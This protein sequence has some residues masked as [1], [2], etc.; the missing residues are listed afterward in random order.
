MFGVGG[1]L[2]ERNSLLL[3]FGWD[4]AKLGV[5]SD[6][7]SS[8]FEEVRGHCF[9][10]FINLVDYFDVVLGN[11]E[12]IEFQELRVGFFDLL[13]GDFSNYQFWT[14][15]SVFFVQWIGNLF[16]FFFLKFWMLQVDDP[17]SPQ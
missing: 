6:G 9:E 14:V 3:V 1:E 5:E 17:I 11:S 16:E 8:M 7:F 12:L 10:W 2:D 15:K 4:A 13:W